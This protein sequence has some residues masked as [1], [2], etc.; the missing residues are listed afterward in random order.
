MLVRSLIF[1]SFLIGG[2]IY[3][4]TQMNSKPAAEAGAVMTFEDK[5]LAVL[6]LSNYQ[7]IGENTGMTQ[8]AQEDFLTLLDIGLEQGYQPGAPFASVLKV[9]AGQPELL[10]KTLQKLQAY[11]ISYVHS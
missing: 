8:L 11:N 5:L 1:L 7:E 6:E 3:I 2:G 9:V 10:D 4:A